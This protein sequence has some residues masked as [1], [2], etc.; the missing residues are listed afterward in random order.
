M[1]V[2]SQVRNKL[3]ILLAMMLELSGCASLY[4]QGRVVPSMVR[5]PWGDDESITCYVRARQ[6]NGLV[7]MAC[8]QA[9]LARP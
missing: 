8:S 7:P 5:S 4:D 2:S 1:G 9:M 6:F 3:A